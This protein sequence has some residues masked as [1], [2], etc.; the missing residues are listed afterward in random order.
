MAGKLYF[1]HKYAE[2]KLKIGYMAR[3]SN[4]E[5]GK[6]NT[7]YNDVTLANVTLGDYSYIAPGASLC[8]TTVGKFCCIGPDVKAG[9]GRH[10]AKGFV[11][12]HPAFFS[13]QRQAGITFVDANKFDEYLP[14]RIGNDVW[15]GANAVI[16]DGVTIGDGAIIGACA[17]V[18]KNIPDY[19][20]AVGNPAEVIR[21]RF[22][23]DTSGKLQ[24][25]AWWD[26]DDERLK[27]EAAF[28]SDVPAFLRRNSGL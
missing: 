2:K 20:V 8:N 10:P 12:S 26:W 24:S 21:Q 28:F 14:I 5:F 16:L 15:I 6:Y 7:L 9:L 13:M 11:S 18:T 17:V 22:E 19:A 27:K 23:T 3:F 4:C 25:I 1:E